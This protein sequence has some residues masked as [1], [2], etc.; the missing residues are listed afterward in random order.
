MA[1]LLGPLF[2]LLIVIVYL[3]DRQKTAVAARR[4]PEGLLIRPTPRPNG[5]WPGIRLPI[6]D[7]LEC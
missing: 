6:R 3:A 5:K 2:L 4:A 7:V 1:W